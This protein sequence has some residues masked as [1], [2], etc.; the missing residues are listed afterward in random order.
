MP[1]RRLL[2]LPL[3]AL[4][5]RASAQAQPAERGVLN[6]PVTLIVPFPAGGPTDRHLRQLAQWAAPL[7]GQP[8]V[9]E[10]RP[11][12]TGLLA[13]GQLAANPRADSH[14]L[15][16]FTASALRAPLM[17]KIGWHPLRDFSFIIGLAL[18]RQNLLVRADSPYRG[19]ADLVQAARQ[20]PVQYGSTGIGSSGHLQMEQL[21]ELTGARFEI[22]PF[23]GSTDLLQALLGGHIS[24]VCDIGGWESL[25]EDN[26]LRLLMTFARQ[27]SRR[28]PHVPTA[29]MMGWHV[30]GDLPYGLVAPKDMDP[31]VQRILY[32]ALRQVTAQPAHDALLEQVNADPWPRSSAEF[33]AWAETRIEQERA[34]LGRLG[35]LAR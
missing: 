19:V 25:V 26:K 28:F 2:V 34:L 10:N 15:C 22:V 13:L 24:A 3:L 30:P 35:L 12:A 29:Q 27:P 5:G 20:Q 31:A 7:L 18:Q 6:R 11:G 8:I 17:S 33:R 9:V 21:A 14:T 23:K 16:H 4:G 32:D 1:R